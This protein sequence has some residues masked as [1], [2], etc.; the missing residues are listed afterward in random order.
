MEYIYVLT[1]DGKIIGATCTKY[2][3]G[4]WDEEPNPEKITVT[5]FRDCRY[6]NGG[7]P[8]TFTLKEYLDNPNKQFKVA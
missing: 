6:S 5:R 7:E 1:K 4:N 3:L 2:R 8:V